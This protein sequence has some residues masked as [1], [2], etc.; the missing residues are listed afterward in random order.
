MIELEIVRENLSFIV[1]QLNTNK[2]MTDVLTNVQEYGLKIHD[3]PALKDYFYYAE[4]TL[5]KN[6]K[7]KKQY[8][9][10]IDTLDPKVNAEYHF[11][12]EV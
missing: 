1:H 12:S 10:I 5:S 11:V 3:V 9:Q 2:K 4:E 6:P 7:F 8:Y